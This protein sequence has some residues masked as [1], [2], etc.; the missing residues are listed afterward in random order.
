M[1]E[2]DLFNLNFNEL[3]YK[4]IANLQGP[5][6]SISIASLFNNAQG[7]LLIICE[8]ILSCSK[9]KDN[10][11]YL[12]PK[13]DICIFHD[14]ETLAYDALSAHQD[15]ISKRI[16]L[17][18][19]I[20][21]KTN[22]IVL[23][24][25]NA[26]MQRLSPVEFI[27]Q[28]SLIYNVNDEIDL[29]QMRNNLI[30]QGYL[31]VDQV[32]SH[33]EFAI[34][35]SIVDIFPAGCDEPY[36][37]DLFDVQ[38]D[39][40][41]TFDIDTQRSL[42]KI[43]HIKLMPAHEFPF[44]KEAISIFRSNY[45]DYFVG[46]NLKNHNIYQAISKGAIPA[47]IEYY[48]PLFFSHTSSL[49]DYLNDSFKII[50][51]EDIFKLAE[52][53]D[54]DTHQRAN[55]FLGNS[56][57]PPL[58]VYRVFLSAPEFI[59]NVK[60]FSY[61]N[62]YTQKQSKAIN[63]K[64]KAVENIAFDHKLDK[65]DQNFCSFV[66]NFIK[67]HGRILLTAQT[68]GRRHALHELIS[69]SIIEQY[70]LKACSNFN[71]FISSNDPLMMSITPF[72]QG[73]IIEDQ[74]LCIIS[75][76]EIYGQQ[77]V[78]Q[79][80]SRIKQ[81]IN[82]DTLIKNLAQ[83][84]IGQHVVHIDHGIGI[85]KGLKTININNVQGEYLQIE[86]QGGD[87][88]SIP[89][90]A[91]SKI[92]RYSGSENPPL[93]KLGNN[94]WGIKKSKAAQKVLDVAAKLLDLYAKREASEGIK[95][96][97]DQKALD[98][99]ASGFGYEE[100]IDQKAAIDAT[101]ADM[102]DKKAMDRLVC[103]DVGFGK[104]EVALRAA[105]VAAY[106]SYQ[107]AILVPTTILAEQHYQNFKERFAS[108][109]LIVDVLSRFKTSSEQN[110]AIKD[111]KDGK[112]DIII[113]TH[114]L[115]SK[116]IKFKKLGLLIVDEEHRFGVR[117]KERLKELRANVDILTLTATP[118]PRTLNMAMEGIRELSIIATAPEHRLAVKTFVMQESEQTCKEAILRELRRGGQ[119]Y[120]LHNDVATIALKEEQL[121][122]IVP[123]A[124]I[125]IAHGQ[126]HE[127]EL[128]KVM[129]DFYHQRY[130][131]LLCTTIVENGLDI[132]T[133]NTIIIDRAD[134]L[135]L[136]QLHQLRGRVGRSHHQAYAYLF[137]PEKSLL[138][139]EAKLRIE[140]IA[141]LEQ[142]GSGFLLATQDL[143]IRGAGEILGDEQSGQIQS[144]GFSLYMDMLSNAVKKLKD[145][146]EVSLNDLYASDCEINMHLPS[147]FPDQYINNISTRLSIYKRLSSCE[148]FEQISDLKIEIID[149]FGP[150]PNEAKNLFEITNLQKIANTLGIKRINADSQGGLIELSEDHKINIDYLVG[151][152]SSCKHNEY[153]MSG[154]NTLRYKI[155]ESE[156]RS[157]I[158]IL[159]MLL[160]ALWAN[161]KL[162]I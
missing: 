27:G 103:G 11:K 107:V 81:N 146:K 154:Q 32:L 149:R 118:I 106:S 54:I 15:I 122:K 33:G 129:R 20:K 136:A 101:I 13:I 78:K 128:Q 2:Q 12:L 119:V 47:G 116:E 65:S 35:G 76:S 69:A 97:L 137:T 99:F 34:R 139:K 8:D 135:G 44:D 126:M 82:P 3:N 68:E 87:N 57:H 23:C 84:Q 17:L 98:E 130:N 19:N 138:S 117:Q 85:Y 114:K 94:S 25:I 157:R 152:I 105:F 124:K 66:H 134:K 42:K 73:L 77:I 127:K 70:K 131:I 120:Y 121:Q 39:S 36:R 14:Y 38:I 100:T 144:V 83:L 45:R 24:P 56:D 4:T 111:I 88:L 21:N 155:P 9:L 43:D 41:S 95:F 92:A 22:S 93:S 1:S 132:P 6:L 72:D 55:L 115:L 53:F 125:V 59:E 71:D 145:K 28:N 148:N 86:Y 10:L 102:L 108:S 60:K 46:A 63:L 16:E 48:L 18:A 74:K 161:S 75:E 156:K 30:D 96:T 26:I 147:L 133:A 49:F 64:L 140:A 158:T 50:C 142:L 29:S 31:Q 141:A 123:E 90:T 160:K 67:K 5:A 61:I 52:Q 153:S 112:I 37:I 159:D 62:L 109:G 150:L 58:E 40:I 91:L 7:S 79:R 151:L 110:K 162:K 80:Q 51:V 89:I 104:T 143:E 113:G